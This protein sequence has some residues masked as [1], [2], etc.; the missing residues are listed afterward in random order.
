MKTINKFST[1]TIV[2][3]TLLF[4]LLS[5]AT[6][7]AIGENDF[8][9]NRTLIDFTGYD[10]YPVNH[11]VI[12]GVTF[13]YSY[14]T[15]DRAYIGRDGGDSNH[16]SGPAL[17][18]NVDEWV[19]HITMDLPQLETMIGYGFDGPSHGLV[20]NA[21]IMKLYN[22]S[23]FIGSLGFDGNADPDWTGGYAGLVSTDPFN[24]VEV[25][26]NTGLGFA[27]DNVSFATP[28]PGS[29]ALL[30]TGIVGLGGLLRRRFLN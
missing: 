24:R 14:H 9:A 25:Y 11:L 4:P 30:G 1:V 13:D 15:A 18:V 29:L 21:T 19:G 20:H 3:I 26:F 2:T 28:E 10:G 17:D 5:A 6:I 23:Q 22:G 7:T 8:P 16:I 27:M 12:Q